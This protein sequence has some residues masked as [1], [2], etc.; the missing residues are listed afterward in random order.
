MLVLVRSIM[1]GATVAVV[2]STVGCSSIRPTSQAVVPGTD[3]R[4]EVLARVG[5]SPFVWFDQDGRENWDYGGNPFGGIGHRA[6]FDESGKLVEWRQLRRRQD[7]SGLEV[8]KSTIADVRRAFGQPQQLY[9]IRGDAHWQW[10][11]DR[12][13]GPF[14]LVAQIAPDGT[15]K[16]LGEYPLERCC[17]GGMP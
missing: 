9:Y 16:G 11:V 6:T 14:R 2:G 7:V 5:R 15:L 12:V 17:G 13:S 3:T 8:G 10:R 1:L 4:A